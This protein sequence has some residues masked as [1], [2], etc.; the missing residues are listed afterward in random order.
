[1]KRSFV[2]LLGLRKTERRRHKRD[3]RFRVR[4][5]GSAAEIIDDLIRNCHYTIS[6]EGVERYKEAVAKK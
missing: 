2:G 6:E 3:H 1:M 4:T 5:V